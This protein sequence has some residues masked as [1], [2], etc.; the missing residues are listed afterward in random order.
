MKTNTL[1]KTALLSCSFIFCANAFADTGLKL[2]PHYSIELVD[3]ATSD[4][5]YSKSTR[6]LHLQPGR[7]QI[8]V[9]F[10]GSFGTARDS[11]MVEAADPIVIDIANLKQDEVLSFNYKLPRS[12][13]EA[14]KY[15]RQQFIELHDGK[16]KVTAD[17]ASFFILKSDSGFAIFRDYRKDLQSINRLYAP[18]YVEGQNRTMSMTSYG[19]PTITATNN[20]SLGEETNRANITMQA[21]GVSSSQ[22]NVM[23][24][25]AVGGGV[26]NVNPQ[27]NDL[28]NLY[29]TAD[30]KTKLE[31]VKYVMSH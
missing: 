26:A 1:F 17:V 7:H 25:S 21:P 30:D 14:K 15:A 22:N 4:Y 6:T 8:V 2:P 27:L 12:L 9:S 10:K 5:N 29:N 11:T 13:D 24:T 20:M 28:I 3:G 19:A 31:F 16:K 23:Q 18:D